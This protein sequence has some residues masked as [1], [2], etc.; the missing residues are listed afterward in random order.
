[1]DIG[2]IWRAMLKN[3]AGFVLIAL[4]IA[5]TMTIMVN[6]FAIM[7]ERA[8][9]VSR[10]SGIDEANTFA[11]ASVSFDEYDSEKMKVLI[12][13]DLALIRGL[14]GVR[15]AV[16]TNS[17]PLRQGGWSMALQLLTPLA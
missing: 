12:D 10:D 1:M 16:A 17:F 9:N 14:P 3:K 13:E 6:A 7:Q 4:Q 15:N 8:N 11:L 5:V 2:P